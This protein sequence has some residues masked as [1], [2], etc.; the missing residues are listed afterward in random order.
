MDEES[1]YIFDIPMGPYDGA[2]VYELIGTFLWEK[3]NDIYN[4]SIIRLYRDDSLLIFRC[5]SG[6]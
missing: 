4:K 5:E 6:T 2:E 3:I 1:G